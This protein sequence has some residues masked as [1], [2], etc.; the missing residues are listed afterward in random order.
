MSQTPGTTAYFGCVGNDEF[1]ER[2]R[3]AAT[4]D[5]VTTCYQVSEDTPT[6]SCA[7]LIK[8]RERS[9]VAN[10]SACNNFK[11]DFLKEHWDVVENAKIFYNE[12]FFLTVSPDSVEAVGKY[13][14]ETGKIYSLNI[15]ALYIVEFFKDAMMRVYPYADY[16]FGNESEALKFSEVHGFETTDIKEIALRMAALDKVSERPRTVVI[17]QGKDPTV[18][19]YNG[20]V[21]EFPVEL[22]P[23]E[24]IVDTNGAGDCNV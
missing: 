16:V 22:I 1:S 10:I 21:Q 18:I 6:G 19:A 23:V 11:I 9:L 8:D 13:A 17:T 5:G 14:A 20:A 3:A 7:V 4:K 24:K 2:L 15:S 12:G